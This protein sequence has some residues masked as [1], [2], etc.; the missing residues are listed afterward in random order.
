MKTVSRWPLVSA[1]RR[2][3]GWST[4]SISRNLV[5]RSGEAGEGCVEVGHMNDVADDGVLFDHTGPAHEGIDADAAFGGVCLAA[6]ED[7]AS[8]PTEEQQAA[9]EAAKNISDADRKDALEYPEEKKVGTDTHFVYSDTWYKPFYSGDD[10]VY[11]VSPSPK[12]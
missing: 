3:A 6:S 7:P 1:P 5:L 10:V 9:T 4:P 11:M 2:S 8:A 12:C